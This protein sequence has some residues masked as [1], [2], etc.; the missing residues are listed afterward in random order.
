VPA[1]STPAATPS[2]PAKKDAEKTDKPAVQNALVPVSQPLEE[3]PKL[4]LALPLA[5]LPVEIDVAIP[6]KA[7]RVRNLL[8]LEPGQ[9]VETRWVNGRDLPL[10]TGDVLLAWSEFEVIDS[11][12]AVR[13]TDMA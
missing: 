9:L 4:K 11:Q 2:T 8:A 1:K 13:V 5:R 7:F 3:K 6:V 10:A 12:L